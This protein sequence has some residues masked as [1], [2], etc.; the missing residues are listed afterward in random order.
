MGFTDRDW[1]LDL[2]C[3]TGQLAVPLANRARVVLALDPEPDM[4]VGLRARVD[5]GGVGNVLAVLAAD[6]DLGAIATMCA[7]S[8]AV[9]T[10]AN[11]LH[12]M[13]PEL[14]FAQSRMLLRMGGGLAV[15]SQGPPMW[16]QDSPWSRIL[17]AFLAKRSGP[18]RASGRAAAPNAPRSIS[19]CKGWAAQATNALTLS[20]IATKHKSIWT[21]WLVICA[22]PC[23]SQRSPGPSKRLRVKPA[24][25]SETPSPGRSADRAN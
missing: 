2:G 9:A 23:L 25:S 5:D 18:A 21:T 10:V 20:S 1:A 3:G 17:R 15:I 22:Q 24:R 19:G 13:D 4:F 12:W 11:A 14:V 16:L 6:R 8:L 7:G